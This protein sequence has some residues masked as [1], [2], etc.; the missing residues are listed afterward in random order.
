MVK[1]SFNAA[2]AQKDAA[3]SKDEEEQDEERGGKGHGYSS[4]VL[5]LPPG[6][7]D[8]GEVVPAGQRRAWFWC[9]CFGLA[10]MLAVV[11]L[12]G[13]YLYRYFASKESGVYF[14]GIKYLEDGL[15]LTEAEA[16]APAPRYH[17]IEE[18]I[19]ILQEEDVEFIS[20]PVPEFADS[21]PADIVHDFHRRLTAYLDL[22]LDKCY[23][24]PLN[25][26]VVMPPKNFLELLINI[27]AGTYL[28]QSY[29]IHEQM[30]V[31][32]RIE[33]VDQ[34]GFFIY[35]LCHG[36]ET[37][38]LQRKETLKGIQKREATNCRIIRHFENRF[39]VETVICE[40][41]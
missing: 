27:K 13:V 24:I 35:R 5:I 2:L 28:P 38:K 29:L 21:D 23:V 33:N 36:K 20:V 8:P 22:S 3:A 12:G 26:S 19:K 40:E 1:V 15:S 9:M 11:I 32:D 37:Y 18:N 7:K 25:M 6:A 10:F 30:I 39:A 31:T 14:C 16:G 34:L 4:Q 17:V 41:Q